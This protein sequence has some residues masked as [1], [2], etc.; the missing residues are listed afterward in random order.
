MILFDSY[1]S[2]S[3]ATATSLTF[4]HTCSGN[5]R[6]LFVM[7]SDKANS[8]TVVTGITYNGTALT[9]INS[10]VGNANLNDR[11]IS[12]WYLVNPSSGANN[13]I[14]SAS[15]SVSLRFSAISYSGVRMINQPDGSDTSTGDTV[16][17]ISTDITT[18]ADNCWMLMFGKDQAGTNTYTSSTGDTMRLATDAGGHFVVDTNSEISPAGSNTMTVSCGNN[19]KVG[20]LAASFS[21][22]KDITVLEGIKLGEIVTAFKITALSIVDGLKLGDLATAFRVKFITI[23]DGLKLGDIL[24]TLSKIWTRITK[25]ASSWT[26]QNRPSSST[27]TPDNKDSN[28]WTSRNK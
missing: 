11:A 1:T 21:P 22:G 28:N 25:V 5:S 7:G 27:W 3:A 18:T 17:S 23:V 2:P 9:Q 26:G 14:V 6:I 15:E 20:V 16:G 24:P 13:V 12:L 4:A 10:L 19:I 8:T